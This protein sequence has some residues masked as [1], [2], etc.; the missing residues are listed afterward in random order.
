MR[1]I[2]TGLI[3]TIRDIILDIRA[4][5]SR[6]FSLSIGGSMPGLFV[7]LPLTSFSFWLEWGTPAA[8]WGT[9]RASA[10]DVEFFLG[11]VRGVLSVEKKT[12]L[13]N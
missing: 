1:N 9:E 8:G 12:E 13:A 4:A 5:V 6:H 2:I 3:E 11:T 7:K 10:T